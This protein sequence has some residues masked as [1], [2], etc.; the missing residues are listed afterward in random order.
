MYRTLNPLPQREPSVSAR[1]VSLMSLSPTDRLNLFVKLL[2]EHQRR[3]SQFV[4]ML[5]P[6]RDSADDVSAERR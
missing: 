5:M 6:D 4:Y 2:V 1:K 3:L